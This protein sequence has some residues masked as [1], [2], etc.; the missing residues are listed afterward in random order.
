MYHKSEIS[1]LVAFIE[2]K[3]NSV[4]EGLRNPLDPKKKVATDS[5]KFSVKS[6]S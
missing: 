3:I 6:A 2:M 5:K 4:I 1:L